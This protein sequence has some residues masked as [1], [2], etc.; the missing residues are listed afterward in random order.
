MWHVV[1]VADCV[2][3]TFEESSTEFYSRANQEVVENVGEVEG[4]NRVEGHLY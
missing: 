1:C 4:S 2:L 3:A